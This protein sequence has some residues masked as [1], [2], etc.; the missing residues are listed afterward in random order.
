M[1]ATGS[2]A[3][4]RAS[5]TSDVTSEPADGAPA[6]PPPPV[7]SAPV[8]PTPVEPRSALPAEFADVTRDASTLRR[9]LHGLPGV[10]AVGVE[11]RAAGLATRSI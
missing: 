1:S 4:K 3:T 11:Q 8:E 10:D 9:F 6:D 2:P 7:E 5:F